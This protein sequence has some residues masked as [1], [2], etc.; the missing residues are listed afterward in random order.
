[1]DLYA[2]LT[3]YIWIEAISGK[4]KLQ[5]KKYPDRC[6]CGRGFTPVGLNWIAKLW[7][8]CMYIVHLIQ[9]Y[10]GVVLLT[11]IKLKMKDLLH[12]L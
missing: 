1:M 4:K 10:S 3:G 7:T 6:A 5:I 2:G 9:H 11:S 12:L 8:R